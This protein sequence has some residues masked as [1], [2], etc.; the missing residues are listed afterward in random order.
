M[1]AQIKNIL[2]AG[3]EKNRCAAGLENMIALV[4]GGRAFRNMVVTCD[5]NHAAPGRGASHVGMLKHIATPV[6]TWALAI[7]N[8]EHTVKPVTARRRKTKL[9]RAPQGGGRQLLIHSGL[10]HDVVRFEVGPRLL[11][12]LVIA[13]QR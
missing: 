4:R 12:C 10:K 1:Q 7:P 5:R 9:L 2:H 8:T 3:R 6:Y 11:Q 13:A